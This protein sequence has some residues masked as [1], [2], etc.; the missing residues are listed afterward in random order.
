M[1]ATYWTYLNFS[2]RAKGAETAAL[3]WILILC[4]M[5]SAYAGSPASGGDASH[6]EVV[7]DSSKDKTASLKADKERLRR[8]D[9]R[10][11]GKSCAV[12]LIGIENRLKATLGVLKVAVML[13]YPYGASIIYDAMKTNEKTL[14]E[15]ATDNDKSISLVAVKETHL[16]TLPVILVPPV[17]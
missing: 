10:I 1:L 7:A 8:L 17:N 12:C 5:N 2:K 14:L 13:R 4:L 11:K 6:S 9:F 3:L 15:A 16:K